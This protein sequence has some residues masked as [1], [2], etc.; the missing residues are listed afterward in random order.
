MMFAEVVYDC[1]VPVCR[2]VYMSSR[3]WSETCFPNNLIQ[4]YE[5]AINPHYCQPLKLP[6]YTKK[7]LIVVHS[8]LVWVSSQQQEKSK[9]IIHRVLAHHKNNFLE[10]TCFI[11]KIHVNLAYYSILLGWQTSMNQAFSS[12]ALSTLSLYWA[13]WLT[14]AI[15]K[16]DANRRS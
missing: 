14:L 4:G 11:F 5:R 8:K 10:I 9:C 13:M 6:R 1:F 2:N 12:Q 3:I 16:Y 15:S 7:N